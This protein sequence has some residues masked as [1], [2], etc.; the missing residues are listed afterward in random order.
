VARVSAQ[1]LA[2]LAPCSL[3]YVQRLTDLQLLGSQEDDGLFPSSDVPLVRLMA[4]FEES[5]IS[6]ED[7]ARGVAGGD[8]SFPRG[9]FC[10]SPPG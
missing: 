2:E 3:E 1:E 10:P 5:G 4:A 9:C 6:L 8:L 7:V